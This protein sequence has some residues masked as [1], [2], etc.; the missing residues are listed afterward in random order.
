MN[1][2]GVLTEELPHTLEV[3]L[4]RDLGSDFVR[5]DKVLLLN[6]LGGE[7]AEGHVLLAEG[8]ATLRGGSVHTKDEVSVLVSVGERVK[9]L[10][11]FLIILGVLEHVTTVSEPVRL[12]NLVVEKTSRVTLTPLFKTE[13]GENI[14][15]NSLTS[16]LGGGPLRVEIMDSVIPSLSG[17]VINF[18]SVSLGGGGPVGNLE[19]LENSSGSSV[20]SNISDSL[21]EG[22]GV[23]VLGVDV[24][25]DIG[26]L[27][28][29]VVVN[30]LNAHTDFTGLLDVESVG[31]E[32]EVGVHEFHDVGHNFF[33]TGAWCKH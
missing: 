19:A 31:D 14:G 10:V 21:E 29:L 17:V 33:G 26:L 23:E 1:S 7:L 28:E 20:E 13:P 12:G 8:F 32:E 5:E 3:R 22:I 25:H 6:D 18:P 24:V 4:R 2:E 15:L 11:A 27:V 30:I 16:E 9:N